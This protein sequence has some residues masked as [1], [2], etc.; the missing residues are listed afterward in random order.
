M[1]NI[2]QYIKS[3]CCNSAVRIIG[4]TAEYFECVKCGN[5]CDVTWKIN[6]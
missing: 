1:S 3:L 5:R 4:R 2:E 6:K